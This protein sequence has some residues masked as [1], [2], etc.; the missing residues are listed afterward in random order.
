MDNPDIEGCQYQQG[1]L[2]GYELREYMLDKWGR[3][4][5]YCSKQNIPLQIEHIVPR[6][7]GGTDR[8][9]NLTLACARCN[10]AKG[11]QDVT[12]FLKKKPDVLKRIL[13]Q[14]KA[15]LK[16]AAV[17]NGTRWALYEQLK[18]LG[19]PIECGSGGARS[20]TVLRAGFPSLTTLMQPVWAQA[21]QRRS[22][23]RVSP[24]CSLQPPVTGVVKCAS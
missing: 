19:L 1:T 24:P 17:V 6:A 5:A 9:S 14:T 10:L 11:A 23:S 4:C 3:T 20:S 12:V 16:D 22:R 8:V 18:T 2:A 15:P 13:A 7:K 21:R